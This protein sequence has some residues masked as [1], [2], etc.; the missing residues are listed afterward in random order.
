MP[1]VNVDIFEHY[2]HI[3]FNSLEVLGILSKSDQ[4][5]NR[6]YTENS[7]FIMLYAEELKWARTWELYN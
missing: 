6:M 5:W 3:F 1:S 2:G 7:N 4:S